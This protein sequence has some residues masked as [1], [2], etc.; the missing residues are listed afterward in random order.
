MKCKK[1]TKN[2]N[3]ADFFDCANLIYFVKSCLLQFVKKM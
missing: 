2:T 3:N 1:L